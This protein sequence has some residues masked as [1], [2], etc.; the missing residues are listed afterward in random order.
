[1]NIAMKTN[2]ICDWL[3]YKKSSKLSQQ[4]EKASIF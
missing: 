3:K 1:M 4:H 2:K